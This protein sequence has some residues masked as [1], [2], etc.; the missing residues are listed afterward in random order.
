M[1]LKRPINVLHLR[2]CRGGGGGP[3]KTILFSAK[4][5]NSLFRQH[6][7]YLRSNH[8]P[9]FDL[10]R[11][12]ASLEI[13]DFFTIGEDGKID[14]SAL[15]QLLRQLRDRDIH[16]LH[17]HCYKSDLYGLILSRFHRMKLVTTVHGPL[18]SLKYFWTAQNWRVRY[19]Y[20]Q[21]DLRL[22][23]FFDHVMM[24]SDSMRPTVRSYGVHPNR[25]TWVKNAID[26][27][28]FRRTQAD[29]R[30]L[31]ARFG[32]PPNATVVGAV[33]RLNGEKDY[34]NFLDMAQLVIRERKDVHFTIAGKGELDG[35][36][37]KRIQ[38]LN[39]NGRVH[40]LGHFHDVRSVY[41]MLD[42]YVLSSTREGLPNTVLEAMAMEVPIAATDV[43]GVSEAAA[44]NR[45]ALLVPARDPA[46][47][48]NAV[49]T[50]LDDPVL[51]RR[52]TDAARTKI[53]SEF[54][55]AARV[56]HEE[57]I[58]AQVLGQDISTDIPQSIN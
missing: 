58:Y 21:L 19:I 30:E 24:V 34:P 23:R 57:R 13:T 31:R 25:L 43:D 42:V 39:L 29:R 50:L 11:R 49:A 32:I 46:R 44:G 51:A 48:A 6:V 40:L 45:E 3:E 1:T 18:A 37:R 26:S 35:F 22:L 53:E 47:L 52:M 28:F 8:D 56:R 20:D 16:V 4:Q 41:E 14:V 55:F 9:E 10:D 7:A 36:L 33:G 15:K 12:A 2:S 27:S 5:G 38:D 17:C 54:S